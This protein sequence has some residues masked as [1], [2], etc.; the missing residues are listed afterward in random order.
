MLFWLIIHQPGPFHLGA[1]TIV[2]NLSHCFPCQNLALVQW[3]K[4]LH[5]RSIHDPSFA[6]ESFFHIS[7][8]LEDVD[9]SR[10]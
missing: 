1:K 6:L 8:G 3:M 7:D 2:H 9:N 4:Y 5:W 10:I